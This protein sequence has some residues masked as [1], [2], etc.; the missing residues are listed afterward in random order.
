MNR[1]KRFLQNSATSL[2]LQGITLISSFI[3][4]RV[5]LVHF[6]SAVNGT[7]ASLSQFLNLFLLTEGGLSTAAIYALYKPLAENDTR[8][9]AL[10]M[11]ATQRLYHK[12]LLLY[13]ALALGLALLYPFCVSTAPLSTQEVSILCLILA[14]QSGL[15]LFLVAPY[16][17]R[18]QAAQR[19]SILSIAQSIV[20]L[21]QVG[22]TLMLAEFGAS[23]LELR[24][25]F[26]L[27][28]IL[29]AVFI[30]WACKRQ[31]TEPAFNEPDEP[32]AAA[33]A[34]IPKRH[35]A[36]YLQVLGALQQTSPYILITLIL[37]N[38]SFVSIYAV[39]TLPCSG[40]A[41]FCSA[42]QS[43]LA[44]GFGELYAKR[45]FKRIK[46]AYEDFEFLFY[47]LI[48][49]IYTCAFCSITPFVEIFTRNVND[50]NYHQP[51]LGFLLVANGLAYHLKSPQGILVS[52]AGLY[53]ET[54]VQTSIQAAILALGG[55]ALAPKF[56]LYGI[57]FASLAS[58]VYRL[59]EQ[60]IFIP[61]YFSGISTQRTFRRIGFALVLPI[62]SVGLESKLPIIHDFSDWFVLAATVGIVSLVFVFGL[63]ILTNRESARR[64][65]L[66]VK[67]IFQ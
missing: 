17:I 25:S 1:T 34:R 42:L 26:L 8:T 28:L 58:N 32:L 54:R 46:E 43:G 66:R 30:T 10:T 56:G 18:L 65:F 21:L 59:V 20:L 35:D 24:A 67:G 51:I 11:R 16:R 55:L 36:L 61:K 31:Q 45:D 40:L 23:I 9:L 4:P 52:A 14:S 47:S 63:G 62:I 27:T 57:A 38:L 37:K 29:R 12:V 50:A 44:S 22:L 60:A 3:I 39:Y 6:G 53:R 49:T 48:S 5:I 41:G 33:K 64:L 15:E 7:I 2:I 19:L 13:G